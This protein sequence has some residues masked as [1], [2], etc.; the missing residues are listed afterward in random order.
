MVTTS[1][2]GPVREF[3]SDPLSSEPSI[4]F[5]TAWWSKIEVTRVLA[6]IVLIST[7]RFIP[8]PPPLLSY[9][10]AGR[11]TRRPISTCLQRFRPRTLGRS[12]H[13]RTGGDTSHCITEVSLLEAQRATQCPSVEL[14]QLF[15]AHVRSVQE[16]RGA[17]KGRGAGWRRLWSEGEGR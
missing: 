7:L 13:R 17:G 4:R 11:I 2:S 8:V 3:Q 6:S 10:R 16:R 12:A 1:S 15:R 5:Q 14:E 9:P